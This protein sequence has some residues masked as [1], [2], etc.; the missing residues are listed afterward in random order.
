MQHAD[1][2]SPQE[3]LRQIRDLLLM[4]DK[5]ARKMDFSW[6]H[7]YAIYIVLKTFGLIAKKQKLGFPTEI[8][9]VKNKDQRGPLLVTLTTELAYELVQFL[10]PSHYERGFQKTEADYFRIT[11][12]KIFVELQKKEREDAG[13]YL[14]LKRS[15]DNLEYYISQMKRSILVGNPDADE[16]KATAGL[17]AKY[18]ILLLQ[19]EIARSEY[20]CSSKEYSDFYN[21]I[22]NASDFYDK[23]SRYIAKKIDLDGDII[24]GNGIVETLSNTDKTWWRM[25]IKEVIKEIAKCIGDS[26]DRIRMRDPKLIQRIK[27][28]KELKKLN[29]DKAWIEIFENP[30]KYP[31]TIIWPRRTY[32]PANVRKWQ[33]K[34]NKENK[35]VRDWLMKNRSI[36]HPD[37]YECGINN[38]SSS[39]QA[40]PPHLRTLFELEWCL[41]R[42]SEKRI[43]PFENSEYPL[44]DWKEWILK[45]ESGREEFLIRKVK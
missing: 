36:Y 17:R 18:E 27:N 43:L 30:D 24:C 11:G 37:W 28:D 8:A 9:E 20:V 41:C 2:K 26:L 3:S 25:F 44:E 38:P 35:E 23:F 22:R 6:L 13:R 32:T 7:E 29:P 1:S 34:L 16:E 40:K 21:S 45:A 33:S 19:V 31:G 42:L 14:E 4:C 12:G 5:M 10:Y 15:S 39:F